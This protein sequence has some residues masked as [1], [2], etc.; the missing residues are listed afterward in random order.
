MKTSHYKPLIE[1]HASSCENTVSVYQ[2]MLMILR[3]K[4]SIM[5]S[6]LFCLLAIFY[7]LN[8]NAASFD[9]TKAATEVEKTICGDSWLE[10]L[11]KDMSFYYTMLIDLLHIDDSK[12]LLE[13]Q[14]KWIVERSRRCEHQSNQSCLVET[15]RQR[16]HVLKYMYKKFKFIPDKKELALIC[17]DLASLNASERLVYGDKIESYNSETNTTSYDINNDGIK[18]VSKSCYA[19]TPLVPCVEYQRAD[20]S[21]MPRKTVDF[22]WE[23]Y[24]TYGLKHF[25]KNGKWFRFHAYD[26]NFESPAYVSYITPENNEYVVCEFDNK[27]PDTFAAMLN[28]PIKSI[29]N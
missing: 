25:S 14:K 17:N 27:N 26:S 22:A 9:C 16:V 15:Y 10:K 3:I 4:G 5:K 19:N 21:R 1:N 8:V 12:K 2:S 20:G 13:E 6:I 23:T 7:T 24:W 11:D 29:S 18:E 28:T